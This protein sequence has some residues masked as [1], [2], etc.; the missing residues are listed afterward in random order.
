[1]TTTRE[2]TQAIELIEAMHA[3]ALKGREIETREQSATGR[4]WYASRLLALKQVLDILKGDDP[5][6]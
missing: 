6:R 5:W 4:L 2:I 3:D 1:M